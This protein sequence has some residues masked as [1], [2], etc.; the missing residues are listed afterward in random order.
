MLILSVRC[1]CNLRKRYLYQTGSSL[2]KLQNKEENSAPAS[3]LSAIGHP[4][5]EIYNAG[6]TKAQLQGMYHNY[7]IKGSSDKHTDQFQ[8]NKLRDRLAPSAIFNRTVK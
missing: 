8:P 2:G 6:K 5:P 7:G 4:H 3:Y 1:L